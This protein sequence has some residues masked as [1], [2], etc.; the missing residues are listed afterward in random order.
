LINT[1]RVLVM[2]LAV[3]SVWLY[4]NLLTDSLEPRTI[5]LQLLVIGSMFGALLMAAAIPEAYTRRGLLFAIVY[6]TINLGRSSIVA[7]ALRH[8]DLGRRPLRAAFWFAVSAVPWLAGAEVEGN[9]RLALWSVAIAI[10]YASAL[11]R[12]PT[13]GIGPTPTKLLNLAT[14]HFAERYRQFVIIALGETVVAIGT[15]LH[16]RDFSLH[17]GTAFTVSFGIT[18]LLF[19]VS[20]HRVREKLGPVFSGAPDPKVRDREAGLAHLLMVIGL[21]A[22]T[23]SS[24]LVITEPTKAAPTSWIAMTIAGPGLF[25]AGHALLARHVFAG[26]AAPRLVGVG[27]LIAAGPALVG[28]PILAASGVVAA[29]LIGIVIWD[30]RYSG[31]EPGDQELPH[32]V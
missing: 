16:D 2:L 13:P 3:W 22:I 18:G 8:D 14:E 19:W 28:L 11:L 4:T 27:V 15:N 21:V 30:L 25:L 9:G 26:V 32:R 17:R 12:W 6:V 31:V 20:F 10:D 5:R 29:V 1:Y 24:E 23:T 7:F